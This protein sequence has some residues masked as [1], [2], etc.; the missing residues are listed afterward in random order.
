M[1]K[2]EITA[3]NVH[4]L[5]EMYEGEWLPSREIDKRFVCMGEHALR[6]WSRQGYI[7]RRECPLPRILWE[8]NV[9]EAISARMQHR[10]MRP[11][12][13]KV[14]DGVEL[15]QCHGPCD[16]WKERDDFYKQTIKTQ[17]GLLPKCKP[18]H[19]ASISASKDRSRAAM[20]VRAEKAKEERL[21]RVEAARS[22]SGFKAKTTVDAGRIAAMIDERIAGSV[23]D[24]EICSRAGVHYEVVRKI[25]VRA[26]RGLD[27]KLEVVDRLFIGLS[28]TN[29]IASLHAEAEEGRPRWSKSYAYCQRCFRTSIPYTARGLCNTCYPHR[30]NPDYRPMSDGKWA[31]R[32]ACCR[33]C[34]T[35]KRR[36]CGKGLCSACYERQRKREHRSR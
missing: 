3:D 22:C 32:W 21:V 2:V 31:S 23:P 30:D 19:L 20:K 34:F 6:L 25:R 12:L 11:F 7:S 1:K 36:H 8:Y 9:S 10:R 15:F 26:R 5:V 16:L 35:T 28:W 33:E 24:T 13:R 4:D 29:E 14:V 27:V 18:C 17:H